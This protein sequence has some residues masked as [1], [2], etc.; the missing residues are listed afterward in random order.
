MWR[1][2]QLTPETWE[3]ARRSEKTGRWLPFATA[4]LRLIGIELSDL[5]PSAVKFE[6]LDND[7]AEQLASFFRQTL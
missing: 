7:G 4:G 6:V 5:V 3:L 1:V 2:R